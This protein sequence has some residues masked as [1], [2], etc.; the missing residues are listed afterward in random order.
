MKQI[1]VFFFMA[2]GVIL[3]R[4][5]S[6]SINLLEEKNSCSLSNDQRIVIYKSRKR[7]DDRQ[8]DT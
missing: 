7:A 5:A 1:E 8:D 3:P 6:I 4:I 2:G